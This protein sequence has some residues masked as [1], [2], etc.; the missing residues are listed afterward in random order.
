[1]V[2]DRVCKMVSATN[3]FPPARFRHSF[4]PEA[5]KAD[6]KL[7]ISNSKKKNGGRTVLQWSIYN[8]HFAI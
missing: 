6:C 4:I 3:D 1:M 8:L 7:K 2:K 5:A